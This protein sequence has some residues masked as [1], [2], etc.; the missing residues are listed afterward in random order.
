M[1]GPN[2][3]GEHIQKLKHF[4]SLSTYQMCSQSWRVFTN[5]LLHQP[6]SASQDIRIICQCCMSCPQ[7]GFKTA[8]RNF[9]DG[10]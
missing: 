10:I 7:G 6:V 5:V 8:A 2:P 4:D 1:G 3:T 9:K